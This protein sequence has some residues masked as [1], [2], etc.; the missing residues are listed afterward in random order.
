MASQKASSA[1][2]S[3]PVN[4]DGAVRDSDLFVL[5]DEDDDDNAAL[6]LIPPPYTENVSGDANSD[7]TANPWREPS[8]RWQLQ[9]AG[10][11]GPPSGSNVIKQSPSS[12]GPG[13]VSSDPSRYYLSPGDTLL[14]VA[15]RFGVDGRELCRLN[16]LP[17][18]TLST[19]PHLLHTRRFITLPSSARTP[20]PLS[21]EERRAREAAAEE[22]RSR[23]L[24]EQAEKR[25]QTL[26]KE[27]DWRVAR[28]YVAIAD[29]PEESRAHGLKGKEMGRGSTMPGT[30]DGLGDR[31]VDWYMDDEEWERRQ[32]RGGKQ[33]GPVPGPPA[34]FRPSDKAQ[35][36]AGWPR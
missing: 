28:A 18:S 30:A 6:D 34:A 11:S 29:D 15:L 27:V 22:H 5:G 33:P 19:T 9:D 1:E 8:E 21:E 23:R 26:T 4:M 12:P 31:A 13:N 17:P 25:F 10:T 3:I 20:P 2:R 7:L 36:L 16:K 32:L 35:T 24:R 14:G